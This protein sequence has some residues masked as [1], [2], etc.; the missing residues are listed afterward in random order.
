MDDLYIPDPCFLRDLINL[1][2]RKKVHFCVRYIFLAQFPSLKGDEV[3]S[4]NHL[5]DS[6]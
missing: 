3:G 2:F 5:L 1:F 4:P 6:I